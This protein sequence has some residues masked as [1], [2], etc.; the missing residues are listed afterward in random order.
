MA[1]EWIILA[2]L[3]II[4]PVM[5]HR[6]VPVRQEVTVRGGGVFD[7]TYSTGAQIIRSVAKFGL[8]WL[9]A[10]R[11][12]QLKSRLWLWLWIIGLPVIGLVAHFVYVPRCRVHWLSGRPLPRSL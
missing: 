12:A 1:W 4:G 6:F 3:T 7:F 10:L 8:V 9:I 2:A 11:L 5:F